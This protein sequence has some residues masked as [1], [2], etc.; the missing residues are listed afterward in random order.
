MKKQSGVYKGAGI[1]LS[2]VVCLAVT[3]CN[4][5][6]EDNSVL[7]TLSAVPDTAIV[8]AASETAGSSY[9]RMPDY[10][11]GITCGQMQGAAS[12]YYMTRAEARNNKKLTECPFCRPAT[13]INM[14]STI[15]GE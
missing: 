7:I 9:H 10:Y 5:E 6:S 13:E 3:G 14:W 12:F 1:L 8:V 11:N 15:K 4:P 2:L